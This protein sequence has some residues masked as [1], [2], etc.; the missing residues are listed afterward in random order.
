MFSAI[1]VKCWHS[2]YKLAP[3][4]YLATSFL[5]PGLSQRCQKTLNKC[6]SPG[7]DPGTSR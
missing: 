7:V 4:D 5:P 1:R 6:N 2:T 3:S